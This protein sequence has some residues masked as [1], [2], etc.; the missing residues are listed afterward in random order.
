MVPNK[1]KYRTSIRLMS[2]LSKDTVVCNI[3]TKVFQ[4]LQ[5]LRGSTLVLKFG[6]EGVAVTFRLIHGSYA[7][8]A[9]TP[10]CCQN[11]IMTE[12]SRLPFVIL[13]CVWV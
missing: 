1:S 4:F 11:S 9:S 12:I 10:I 5:F 6:L 13:V 2:F 7:G 3:V 8:R